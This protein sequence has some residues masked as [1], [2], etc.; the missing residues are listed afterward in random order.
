MTDCVK[1]LPTAAIPQGPVAVREV[2]HARRRLLVI[3]V[4]VSIL[5]TVRQ[6]TEGRTFAATVLPAAL[7]LGLLGLRL[8]GA[9]GSGRPG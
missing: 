9:P 2:D 1:H 3:P 6:N 7:P 4:V 5:L 8:T